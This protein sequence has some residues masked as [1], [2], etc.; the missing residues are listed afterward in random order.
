MDHFHWLPHEIG[1]LTPR[2][3]REYAFHA[4]EESGGIKRPTPQAPEPATEEECVARVAA[5]GVALGMPPAKVAAAVAQVR[6]HYRK[7]KGQSNG[8]RREG[9]GGDAG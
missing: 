1:R 8:D 7:R 4:R 3:I 6:E 9:A 2:Q 5:Q